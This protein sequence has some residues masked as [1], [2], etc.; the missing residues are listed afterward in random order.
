MQ[1][2]VKGR[3]L[4]V[5]DSIRSYVERKLQSSTAESTT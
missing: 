2:H 1:L 3:N 5:N 4:E